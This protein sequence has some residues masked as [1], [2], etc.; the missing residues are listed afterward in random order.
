MEL[1]CK[2]AIISCVLHEKPFRLREATVA[3]G[4]SVLRLRL[5]PGSA[6]T[7]SVCALH[8]APSRKN[9]FEEGHARGSLSPLRTTQEEMD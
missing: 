7:Q 5:K 6:R 9:Y 3:E 2:G 8:T 1:K 4:W